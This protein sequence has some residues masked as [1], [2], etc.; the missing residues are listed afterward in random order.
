MSRYGG[1]IPPSMGFPL[2]WINKSQVVDGIS[3]TLGYIYNIY[4]YIVKLPSFLFQVVL[5]A[6]SRNDRAI[7]R[8][9][10]RAG[11]SGV[12]GRSGRET[13]S[14]G[15]TFALVAEPAT[16]AHADIHLWISEVT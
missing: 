8:R 3:P 1:D 11:G 12:N 9:I 2:L 10:S 4:M 6:F 15:L 7:L 13:V 5:V 14:E 16:P